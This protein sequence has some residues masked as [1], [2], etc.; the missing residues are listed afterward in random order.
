LRGIR[1]V[2]DAGTFAGRSSSPAR[3]PAARA[4]HRAGDLLS[5]AREMERSG[6][7][8]EAI[9]GYD[10]AITA[11]ESSGERTVLA[12]ALRRSGVMH[13]H[14]NDVDRARTACER[15]YAVAAGVGHALLAAEALNALAGFAFE[16]GAIELA[17]DTFHRALELGG[18][19]LELRA[20]IEQNLG[21]LANIQGDVAGALGHYHRS[22]EACRTL[23]DEKGCAIAY[24]NLGMLSADRELWDDADRYYRLSS[25]IAETIGDVHL[26]GLC[27]LN[28]AEVHLAR[29]CYDLARQSA[30]ASL[31]IFDQLGA[32]L[33]KA[34]AYKVIGVVFRETGR[35]ALAESRLRAAIDHAV[36][37]GSVL[38]E[39]ESSRELA[40]L[41]QTMG[42][43]QEA[44]TLLNAAHRL[45]GRLEARVD[46]VD[47]DAKRAS[48]E[49]TFLA[50][51]RDWGQSIESADS[52][53]YG[54]CERVAGYAIQVARAMGL[55][56]NQQTTMRLGA[57]L[58]DLGKVRVP[59]EILNKA[60]PLTAD[61]FA[62][63]QMH[64]VWGLELLATVEFPWDLKPIIRW[65]HEKYDGSGYPD[66]LRGDEIPLSAQ[67]ICIADVFDALTTTRS[68]RGALPLEEALRRMRDS[69]GWWRSDVYDAFMRTVGAGAA[70]SAA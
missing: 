29:Q 27:L 33:D 21:I 26:R 69:R 32:R 3:W 59:H 14:R 42:R 66:R 39:A 67:I 25:E 38:S 57:Y 31:G 23:G 45:F 47:V 65:H 15:S 61:E 63:M 10:S 24:H 1:S 51:V 48:L 49:D 22:L 4:D 18:D 70:A 62:V 2:T 19:G 50:I 8:P 43:N 16:T 20:R 6:C 44:L 60:G 30:E 9:E 52:Y 68:Y 11:A 12:E 40:R 41:Y 54:H 56:E 28:H 64:P 34:D 53:T 36:S 46:L 55:D 7:V 17:R 13:F 37:T 5:R 58:H 35:Y